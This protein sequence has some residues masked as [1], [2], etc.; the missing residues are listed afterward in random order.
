MP[1]GIVSDD[2]FQVELQ[3]NSVITKVEIKNLPSPGRKEGDNNVP[4]S[5][6]KIIGETSEI[7]GRPAALDLANKF[8][9]SPSSVSAYA[10]G[11]TSTDSMDK[12]PNLSHIN[13]AKARISKMARITLR[14]ALDNITDDK[15]VDSKATDLA[16]IARS[17][18]GIV[19]EMEPEAPKGSDNGKNGP[20][21]IFY[22]PH[23]QKQDHYDIIDVKE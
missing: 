10:N 20:T 4:D 19:K 17:M 8:G 16:V 15:L 2:D 3:R 22:S 9:I 7:D 13:K 5:L 12:Q 14:K 21:F 23:V 11:S 1:M 18:S 6:R